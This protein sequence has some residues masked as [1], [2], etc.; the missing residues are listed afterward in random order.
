MT[1]IKSLLNNSR[2][3]NT[4]YYILSAVMSYFISR[5]FMVHLVVS[6]TSIVN[7]I[8]FAVSMFLLIRTKN[9]ES[10][11]NK[12]I[13][14][15]FAVPF[16][17]FLTFGN[18]AVDCSTLTTFF[19]TSIGFFVL[20]YVLFLFLFK[21]TDC[22]DAVIDS[23]KE[24]TKSKKVFWLS[25][26]FLLAAWL[27]YFLAY[28][29]GYTTQDSIEQIKQATG[30]AP[31]CNW[32]P[33]M[34]TLIVKLTYH[35]GV[36]IFKSPMGGIAVY[37]V[38]QSVLMGL[39]VSYFLVTLYK[40]RINKTAIIL[41]FLFFAFFP[42]IPIYNITMWKDIYFAIVVLAFSTALW[43]LTK[44]FESNNTKK[45]PAFEG[46]LIFFS[47]I[48]VCLFRSN[49]YYAFL[50][51][52]PFLFFAFFKR[53]KKLSVLMLASFIVATIIKVP[54]YTLLNIENADILE[55]VG[56]P[57][58]HI[59][60]AAAGSYSFTDE[61]YVYITQLLPIE[62]IRE[63]YDPYIV[64]PIK[65]AIRSYNTAFIIEDNKL[66]FLKMWLSIGLKHPL[67][68]L[69]GQVLQTFGYW[70][71][72]TRYWVYPWIADNEIGI[73]KQETVFSF[74]STITNKIQYAYQNIPIISILWCIGAY[75]WVMILSFMMS[76]QRRM[77]NRLVVYAVPLAVL[78]SLM[79][80]TPVFAEFRYAYSLV[81]CAPLFCI[82]PFSEKQKTK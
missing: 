52:L 27:I 59:C 44:Y 34:H 26:V 30:L 73:T 38:V 56:V 41:A 58:Q 43:R 19:V 70:Y 11:R 16:A 82:L 65:N 8:V 80:A 23:K 12:I 14:A 31:W 36:S 6:S 37:S 77:K 48:G 20:F 72:D 18:Y 15:L 79:L 33:V 67:L 47:A 61:Q 28:F 49:G 1:K 21:L 54:V 29:P 81:L 71:P 25:F 53:S 76:I 69:K 51:S 57:L 55:T 10:R 60:S 9:E 63:T 2:T 17:L 42:I 35:A 66:L 22:R 32:H 4:I 78:A 5:A 45:L 50:I 75:S 7:Y 39:T 62:T 40:F 74:L 46:T 24:R 68:Y 3:Q 64:D 13:S